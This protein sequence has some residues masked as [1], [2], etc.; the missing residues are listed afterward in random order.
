MVSSGG[1]GYITTYPWVCMCVIVLE[2]TKGGNFV[3]YLSVHAL[4]ELN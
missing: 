3:V 2:Y 1:F 4:Q